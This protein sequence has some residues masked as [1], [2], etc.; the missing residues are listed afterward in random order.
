MAYQP[1]QRLG[2]PNQRVQEMLD[3]LCL[4]WSQFDVG[5][6]HDYCTAH[7]KEDVLQASSEIRRNC[8]FWIC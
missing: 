8:K 6:F 5:Q 3:F 2:M 7:S 4:I 1:P